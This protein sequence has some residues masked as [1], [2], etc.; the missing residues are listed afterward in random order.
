MIGGQLRRMS[1]PVA[2]IS[3]RELRAFF[4]Q[5]GKTNKYDFAVVAAAWFPELACR[6]QVKRK[7][8]D[9][10]PWVMTFF[11]AIA[12]GTAYLAKQNPDSAESFRRP[13]V[14]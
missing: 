4:R 13:S 11:D 3:A 12:L 2:V 9:P 6:L 5:H 8:Y 14:A 1:V 10:E 7:W